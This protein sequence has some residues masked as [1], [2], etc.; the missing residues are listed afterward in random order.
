MLQNINHNKNTYY[1]VTM[2]KLRVQYDDGTN[3]YIEI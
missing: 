3:D 2:D 1:N